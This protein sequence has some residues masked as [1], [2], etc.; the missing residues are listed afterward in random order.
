MA[1]IGILRYFRTRKRTSD[2]EEIASDEEAG[3][4]ISSSVIVILSIVVTVWQ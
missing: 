4:Q 1:E 2:P 3:G